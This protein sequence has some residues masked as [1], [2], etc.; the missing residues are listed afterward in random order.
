ME[1]LKQWNDI[2]RVPKIF[3]NAN[4]EEIKNIYKEPM[5][6]R[7][8]EISFIITDIIRNYYQ[9]LEFS[10]QLKYYSKMEVKLTQFHTY[11]N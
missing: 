4:K 8:S 6:G 11:K 3:D 10:T 9:S 2:Y 1:A 5:I 7:M